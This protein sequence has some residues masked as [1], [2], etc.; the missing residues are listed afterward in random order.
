MLIYHRLAIAVAIVS[1]LMLTLTAPASA[2]DW[3][4]RWKAA[5]DEPVP[6]DIFEAQDILWTYVAVTSGMTTACLPIVQTLRTTSDLLP[7]LATTDAAR[8]VALESLKTAEAVIKL[9]TAFNQ[10]YIALAD[11]NLELLKIGMKE[12]AAMAETLKRGEPIALSIGETERILRVVEHRQ[13]QKKMWV[14]AQE[15]FAK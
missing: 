10:R 7:I 14:E 15:A 11:F 3:R 13:S 12:I 1:S 2:E 6:E 5:M 9:C 8:T 4:S